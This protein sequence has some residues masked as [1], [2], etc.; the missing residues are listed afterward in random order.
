MLNF[1]VGMRVH[2]NDPMVMENGTVVAVTDTSVEVTWDETRLNHVFGPNDI[3]YLSEG[4]F[5]DA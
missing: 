1:K 3:V 4:E 2:D 5:N